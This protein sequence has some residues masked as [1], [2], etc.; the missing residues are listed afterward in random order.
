MPVTAPPEKAM[1]NAGFMPARAAWAVRV[2][3][4]VAIR[5]PMFPARAEKTEP[6]IKQTEV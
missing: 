3:A 5:M 6:I 2:L 4:L 1:A